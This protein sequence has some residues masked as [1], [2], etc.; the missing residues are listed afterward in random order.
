M[1]ALS[2]AAVAPPCTPAEIKTVALI[3]HDNKKAE[4]VSFAAKHKDVLARFKLVGTGTTGTQ[5]SEATG[6]IIERMLSGPL[7]GD[8]QIGAKVATRECQMVLF[9]IDPLSAHPHDPDIHGLHRVCN[10]HG[11]PI[12]TN[13]ATA[14]MLMVALAAVGKES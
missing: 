12:A 8:Q 4:M 3:A 2:L 14:E 7:G 13:R 1:A 11:V 5:V 10:V 9:F 6:L